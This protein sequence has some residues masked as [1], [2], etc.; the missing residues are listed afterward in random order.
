[1]SDRE[2]SSEPLLR[3]E[4]LSRTY[5]DG[6]VH[7]LRG[8]SLEIR[9][10][11]SIAIV[12][13]S[14]C[15]KSTLLHLLGGLDR[16]TSG[17]VYYK[18]N[19]LSRLDRDRYRALEIG[20]V[21]QSFHILGTLNAVEN[22]QIPMFETGLSPRRRVERAE[23]LIEQVGLAHRRKARPMHLSVGE[24]QRVAIARAL[25]NEPSVLLADE[26]TG[27]LDSRSQSEVL[28]LLE[29]LRHRQ[30]LTLVLITHSSEVAAAAGRV[31][32]MR[33]GQV[34]EAGPA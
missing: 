23:S 26:P 32:R 11:E 21:F 33:D 24:R 22:V 2:D 5:P 1:M 18:G 20:F 31:I 28:Q 4:A 29:D 10:N 13:P 8:V 34:V 9:R 3:G 16:P 27:N 19:P 12:G 7:A 6:E 17:E 25:A 14:G 30:G 15:G